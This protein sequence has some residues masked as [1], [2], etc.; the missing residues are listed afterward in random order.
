MIPRLKYTESLLGVGMLPK[1]AVCD[2][3]GVPGDWNVSDEVTS[4]L[5]FSFTD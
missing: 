5:R 2:E 4:E 3:K 1:F